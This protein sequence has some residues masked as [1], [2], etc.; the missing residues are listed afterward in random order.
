MS[1][2]ET[3]FLS[4]GNKII[5]IQTRM[6]IWMTNGLIIYLT[7]FAINYKMISN[8]KSRIVKESDLKNFHFLTFVHRDII[9]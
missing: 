1:K 9:N 5:T 4:M 2:S 3:Q 8:I 7:R 6:H